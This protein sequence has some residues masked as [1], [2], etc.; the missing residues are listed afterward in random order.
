MVCLVG[1][2]SGET[3]FLPHGS[4]E[5]QLFSRPSWASHHMHRDADTTL[6]CLE[7]AKQPELV[8]GLGSQPSAEE[9]VLG[10]SRSRDGWVRMVG[11]SMVFPS[12]R[13]SCNVLYHTL[14]ILGSCGSEQQMATSFLGALALCGRSFFMSI[15]P[16]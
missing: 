16:M 10:I 8:D 6:L 11:S 9:V 15:P 2:A 13:M 7:Q 4:V 3:S 12:R 14:E 1:G 5:A